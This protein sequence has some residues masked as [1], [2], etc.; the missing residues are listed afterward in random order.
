MP[1]ATIRRS[2]VNPAVRAKLIRYKHEAGDML[3]DHFL[4]PLGRR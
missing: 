2:E 3:A 1:L 4:G